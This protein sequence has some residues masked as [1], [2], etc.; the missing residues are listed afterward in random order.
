[1][2]TRCPVIIRK[3]EVEDFE[4]YYSLVSE[5]HVMKYITGKGLTK[6]E[7]QKKFAEIIE[8]NKEEEELGYFKVYTEKDVHIGDCKLERYERD[9]NWLEIGYILKE[10]YWGQ[11]Y[12]SLICERMLLLADWV[13]PDA[14]VIGII[15]PQ[16]EASKRLLEKF[17]FRSFFIGVEDDLPTEKLRLYRSK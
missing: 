4:T 10:S 5:D 3:Y 16:N 12:G 17:N 7:A 11:G 9:K 6:P 1:M 14:D 8:I 13:A 15:D 2:S